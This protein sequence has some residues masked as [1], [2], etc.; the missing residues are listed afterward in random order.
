MGLAVPTDVLIVVVVA[1]LVLFGSTKIPEFFRSLGKATGEFKK[2]KLE[3]EL[4]A[5]EI[6][7]SKQNPNVNV[8]NNQNQISKED[9]ERQIKQL[10]DQLDQLKKQ[11]Q[12]Q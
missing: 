5:E 9:L 4:E 2:G 6:L 7:K 8:Q 3:S 1:V 12:G 11:N 10:Q